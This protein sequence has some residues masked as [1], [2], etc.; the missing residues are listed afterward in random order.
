[1]NSSIVY[2]FTGEHIGHVT[3]FVP[4]W[5]HT[6]L[7]PAPPFENYSHWLKRKKS[8][9]C[10]MYEYNQMYLTKS[11][12]MGNYMFSVVRYYKQC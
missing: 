6:I 10:V 2:A 1:M 7:C 9:C 8:A 12:L 4:K 5:W 11:L 3:R